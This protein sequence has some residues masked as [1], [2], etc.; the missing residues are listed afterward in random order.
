MLVEMED[1]V[2]GQRCL[3]CSQIPHI[4]SRFLDPWPLLPSVPGNE[5]GREETGNQRA[6]FPPF[7]EVLSLLVRYVEMNSGPYA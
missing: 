4:F 6:T 1:S 5:F 2:I 3:L 7:L